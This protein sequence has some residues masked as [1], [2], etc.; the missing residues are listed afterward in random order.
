METARLFSEHLETPIGSAILL[1]DEGDRVHAFGWTA[2]ETP[3]RRRKADLRTRAALPAR[4]RPSPALDR[5]AHYFDGDLE[6]LERIEVV[7][8]GTPFQQTVWLALRRIPVGQTMS[9]GELA[10]A[11]DRPRA[12]RAVGL[13]NGA[14]PIGVIVPC[15]RVIGADASLTGYGAGLSRKEWLLAHEGVRTF[16]RASAQPH[17]AGWDHR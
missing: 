9:Y 15:H 14:N 12:V 2:D 5:L 11:I 4:G 10:V 1:T 6:A 7:M 16:R 13:A 3:R 17:L 8:G